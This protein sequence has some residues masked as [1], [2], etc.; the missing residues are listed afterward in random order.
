MS[1]WDCMHVNLMRVP[2]GAPR[3]SSTGGGSQGKKDE[4]ES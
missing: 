4:G 3:G 1:D 2:A